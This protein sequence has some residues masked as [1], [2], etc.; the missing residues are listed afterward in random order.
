MLKTNTNFDPSIKLMICDSMNT[1]LIFLLSMFFDLT[2]E[3]N[4]FLIRIKNSSSGPTR[5]RRKIRKTRKT[6]KR[7][8]KGIKSDPRVISE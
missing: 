7:R 4:I 5:K 2:E 6:R 3:K 1:L 8:R